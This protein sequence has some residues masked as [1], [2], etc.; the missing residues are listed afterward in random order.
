MTTL[1]IKG[2]LKQYQANMVVCC[3]VSLHFRCWIMRA[4]SVHFTSIGTD[5][6][7]II[8]KLL[9]TGR[10]LTVRHPRRLALAITVKV[11]AHHKGYRY[12]ETHRSR[13]FCLVI[14]E[15]W[16]VAVC[17]ILLG[18]VKIWQSGHSTLETLAEDP[19]LGQQK[20]VCEVPGHPVAAFTLCPSP[21]LIA[22]FICST[23]YA[24]PSAL[25]S[26]FCCL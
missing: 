18:Q 10:R 26:T 5:S 2:L 16:D 1:N 3:L 24:A 22:A 11:L 8:L 14:A 19:N 21:R 15:S 17:P 12:Y 7:W 25:R 6:I 4:H 20:I 9:S 13:R 23:G